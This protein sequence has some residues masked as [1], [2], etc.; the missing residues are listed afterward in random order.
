MQ[1]RI[2]DLKESYQQINEFNHKMKD[3][4]VEKEGELNKKTIESKCYE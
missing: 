2:K 3:T 4:I 1:E